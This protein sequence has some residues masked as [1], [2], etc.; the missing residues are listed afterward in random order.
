MDKITRQLLNNISL[1]TNYKHKSSHWIKYTKDFNFKYGSISG[2]SGFSEET[3]KLP[4]LGCYHKILQK[5]NFSNIDF[6]FDDYWYKTANSAMSKQAR[7]VDLCV[8]RQVF[9]LKLLEEKIDLENIN[10]ICVIGDGQSNFVAI[11]L[12]SQKFKKVLSIN[13]PEVLLNDFNL[14]K[15]MGFPLNKVELLET[16]NQ[17]YNYL[18]NENIKF[19]MIEANNANILTEEKIDLFVNIASFGEMNLDIVNNYFK[20]IKSSIHG[21]YLY[22]CNREKKELP[23]GTITQEKDYPWEGFT[24]KILDE[25]APWHSSYYKLRRGL[26]PIPK[27][28]IPFDGPI[29]HKLLFYPSVK[30]K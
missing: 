8:L 1:K 18:N 13:L 11:A 23:D 25:K 12:E 6:S 20:I 16:K 26:I 7:V 14:I 9:T 24:Q 17:V 4:L 3:K 30:N 2:I 15:K 27:I 21:T 28:K 22:S 29:I 19:G 5:F 10:N